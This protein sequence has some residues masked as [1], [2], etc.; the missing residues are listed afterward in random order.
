[1]IPNRNNRSL[2][3]LKPETNHIHAARSS[4]RPANAA[5]NTVARTTE[6]RPLRE[7]VVNNT[8]MARTNKTISKNRNRVTRTRVNS[9]AKIHGRYRFA[10]CPASHEGSNAIPEMRLFASSSRSENASCQCATVSLSRSGV[11]NVSN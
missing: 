2:P 3:R 1:M 11:W 9:A 5:V 4:S 10:I 8:P 7:Y 6:S